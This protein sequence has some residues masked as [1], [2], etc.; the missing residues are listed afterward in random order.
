MNDKDYI[1]LISRVVDKMT[2]LSNVRFWAIW[3]L[4]ALLAVGYVL[5]KLAEFVK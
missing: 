4:F 2:N 5:G 1:T 3:A